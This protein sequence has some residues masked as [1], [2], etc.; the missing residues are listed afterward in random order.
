MISKR[1]GWRNI[2][3]NFIGFSPWS[4]HFVDW[5]LGPASSIPGKCVWKDGANC[6][7][8]LPQLRNW[9]IK[10][11][12][13]LLKRPNTKWN[14]LDCADKIKEREASF[15]ARKTKDTPPKRIDSF[16]S[17]PHSPGMQERASLQLLSC[18]YC[19][20]GWL[21]EN[22]PTSHF[23]FSLP[24]PYSIF[25]AFPFSF[26]CKIGQFLLSGRASSIFSEFK[27]PRKGQKLWGFRQ[28]G[29]QGMN[30]GS[31]RQEKFT[32]KCEISSG[33]LRSSVIFFVVVW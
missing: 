5:F 26:V 16:S 14:V 25:I 4:N 24:Q 17:H 3:E 33:E 7:S 31:P 2:N 23:S 19:L 18:F 10:M 9:V 6:Y 8:F 27:Y 15:L 12:I 30:H 20:S 28:L 13:S 29:P 32:E 22:S 11:E 21:W 1:L